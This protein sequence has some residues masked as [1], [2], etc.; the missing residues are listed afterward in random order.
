MDTTASFLFLHILFRRTT[1]LIPLVFRVR[2]R[3]DWVCF[4]DAHSLPY[5]WRSSDPYGRAVGS[6]FHVVRPLTR[7]QSLVADSIAI[8]DND[9]RR[10]Q[11]DYSRFGSMTEMTRHRHKTVYFWRLETPCYPL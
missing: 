10:Q 11:G 9:E 8:S 5:V 7:G 6:V 1:A 2:E 4:G 3:L